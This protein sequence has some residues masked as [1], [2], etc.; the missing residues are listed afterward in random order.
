MIKDKKQKKNINGKGTRQKIN[1]KIKQERRGFQ[2]Y[3]IKVDNNRNG[4][5]R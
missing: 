5:D 2:E 4:K 1:Q 3:T